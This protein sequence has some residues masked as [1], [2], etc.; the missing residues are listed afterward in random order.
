VTKPDEAPRPRYG[1]NH[2]NYPKLVHNIGLDSDGASENWNKGYRELTHH[3]DSRTL[4][5]RPPQSNQRGW[6]GGVA[7]NRGHGRGRGPYTTR[8]LYCMYH[9][10]ETNHH[11]KDCPIYIGTKHKMNQGT[12]QPSPQLHSREINHTMQWAPRNQQHSSLYPLHYPIQTC[13]NSQ[14]QPS[15]YYQQYH[16]ATPNYP[17]PS[18]A[19]QMTYQSALP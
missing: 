17:E 10:N 6:G 9:D 18:P 7:S 14:T 19:T 13:Q 8:P 1:D 5:Q 11:T 4:N 3:S 12:T 15:S 2:R 16:Y